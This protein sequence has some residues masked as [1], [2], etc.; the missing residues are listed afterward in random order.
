MSEGLLSK[1]I[2]EDLERSGM[3]YQCARQSGVGVTVMSVKTRGVTKGH[4]KA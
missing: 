1:N 4:I 2:K 3:L